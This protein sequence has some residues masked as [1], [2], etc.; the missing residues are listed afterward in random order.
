[1]RRRKQKFNHKITRKKMPLNP[2]QLWE[3]HERL[4]VESLLDDQKMRDQAMK[5]LEKKRKQT[6]RM[7]I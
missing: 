1:M 4:A 7:V 6:E 2:E 5:L 3:L